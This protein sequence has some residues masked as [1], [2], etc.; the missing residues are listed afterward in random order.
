MFPKMKKYEKVASGDY[1]EAEYIVQ[2]SRKPSVL[3]T[4]LILFIL[5]AS[6]TIT[7]VFSVRNREKDFIDPRTL[8]GMFAALESLESYRY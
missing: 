2:S 4:I 1:E 3:N 5:V 6:N 7:W 8:Y